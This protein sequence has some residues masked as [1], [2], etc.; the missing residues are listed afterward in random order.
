MGAHVPCTDPLCHILGIKQKQPGRW[1]ERAK[2]RTAGRWVEGRTCPWCCRDPSTRCVGS[3]PSQQARAVNVCNRRMCERL[4]VGAELM[5]LQ[6]LP[7]TRV[8]RGVSVMKEPLNFHSG[9]RSCPLQTVSA[10]SSVSDTRVLSS[11]TATPVH[12]RA[13]FIYPV[14]TL[15]IY[16]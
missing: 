12:F 13:V 1:W 4:R 10:S 9:K 7:A 6:C 8:L 2:I 3:G 5:A 16:F 15:L 11:R 14:N